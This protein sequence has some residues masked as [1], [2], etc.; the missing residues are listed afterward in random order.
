MA[1]GYRVASVEPG[2]Q[3]HT[4][5]RA[6]VAHQ[7]A[8]QRLDAAVRDQRPLDPPRVGQAGDEGA[9]LKL[10]AIVKPRSEAG[11]VVLGDLAWRPPTSPGLGPER[12]ERGDEIVKGALAPLIAG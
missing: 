10:G 12:A 6:E 3:G 4:A 8:H 7:G 11:E 9:D 1:A 5:E 2:E